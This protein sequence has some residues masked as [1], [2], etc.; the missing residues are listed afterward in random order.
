MEVM[1]YSEGTFEETSIKLDQGF[2]VD[3]GFKE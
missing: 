3:Q 1:I 2:K